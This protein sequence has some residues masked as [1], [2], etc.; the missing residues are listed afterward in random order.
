MERR[1]FLA[2]GAGALV[3]APSV[4]AKPKGGRAQVDLPEG[5]ADRAYMVDL[6]GR[7]S[8]PV[9]GPMSEGRLHAV[10]APELSPSWDGRNAKV[11]Y[12]ECFGR[13][14]S[15]IAPWLALADDDGAEGRLRARLRQQALASYA[16]SVD[17]GSPDYLLWSVEPQALVD[18][19]YFT[20]ALLRAPKALWAPLDSA[21]KQ[22]IIA[23]I[24]GLRRFSPPYT[25]WLLFA[26][27]NEAFLL[28]VGEKW[29][30][31]RID[32]AIRK[33][34]EWYVG[35]GWYADG[36]RF[37]YDFYGS[38]V[39]HPML[40]EILEVLVATGAK[41]NSLATTD[42]LAQATKRMQR[43]GEHLERMIAPDGSYAPIG[44]SLT[45]RTAAFQPLGL[46]AWRKALPKTL[47]EGQV[48]AATLAAQ[49]A[50][51]RHSGNFDA[52]GYLTIGFT[53]HQPHLGDWYSNAGSMYIAAESLIALGLPGEDSYWTAPPQAWTSRKAFAG[54]AFPKD[55][56]V[57]Y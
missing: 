27:M 19:A 31:V 14:I 21:T 13:L 50:V 9:L 15:G 54:D 43:Y 42:L 47:P 6:L 18:S 37:H 55:Y 17:P 23:E 22:R 36:P 45:Y 7:M 10:F 41:F 35:D 2:L 1:D 26:A 48:R 53:D 57:D 20:N 52:K 12:L 33:I 5:S 25:N 8:A 49:R 44:R 3:A 30:P 38:Y 39:I 56:Y 16:H 51:F 46:L 34:N 28:S 11:A 32:L 4:A 24:K 40:V 29:D